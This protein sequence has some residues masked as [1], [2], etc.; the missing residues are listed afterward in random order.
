M[1]KFLI[2]GIIVIAMLASGL[3]IFTRLYDKNGNSESADRTEQTNSTDGE[4]TEATMENDNYMKMYINDTEVSVAWEN[5]A[6]VKEI[7]NA[8]PFTISMSM[9]GGWEQVGSF[10]CDFTDNDVKQKA[11]CGDLMLYCGNKLVVFYGDN[12]WEYTKLGHIERLSEDEII[13]LL[14]NGDVTITIGF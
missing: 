4:I 12:T 14:S 8:A 1:R 2:I 5:N 7:M 6:T 10:G 3:I 9:Y 11:V 13:D